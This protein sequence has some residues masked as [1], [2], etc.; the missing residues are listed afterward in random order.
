MYKYI[1]LTLLT[2]AL[3]CAFL[4]DVAF[5]SEVE[6]TSISPFIRMGMPSKWFTC[7]GNKDCG[8]FVAECGAKY[9]VNI[10]YIYQARE[11]YCKLHNGCRFAHCSY[12]NIST[13][14]CLKGFCLTIQKY[15]K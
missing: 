2:F 9:G 15:H 12:T 11:T 4:P 7:R 13:A 10:H 3:I 5:S 14:V 8:F 1:T 6:S